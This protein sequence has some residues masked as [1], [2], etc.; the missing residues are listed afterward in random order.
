MIDGC[1]YA[2]DGDWVEN[3]TVL[4]ERPDGTL[5]ILEFSSGQSAVVDRLDESGMEAAA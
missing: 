2:N 4:A 5:E 1:L 3:G